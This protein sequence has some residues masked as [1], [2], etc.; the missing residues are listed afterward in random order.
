MEYKGY[1]IKACEKQPGK[2]RVRVVRTSAIPL[3]TRGR[4]KLE[5][6]MSHI[7]ARTAVAAA[8]KAMKAVDAA[9]AQRPER[10]GTEK[11]WRLSQADRAER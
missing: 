3:P 2:W 11:F 4:K 10:R 5:Q 8:T 6:F 1:F 9:Y 7:E